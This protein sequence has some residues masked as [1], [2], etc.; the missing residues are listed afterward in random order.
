MAAGGGRWR[1]GDRK[2]LAAILLV[3]ISGCTRRQT[4]EVFG[5]SWSTVYRRFTEWSGARSKV[6][7]VTERTGL[8]LSIGIAA[9]DTRDSLGLEP[10]GARDP[11]DPIPPPTPS[12]QTCQAPRRQG[13]RLREPAETAPRPRH[14]APHR[15]QRHRKPRLLRRITR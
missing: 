1:H 11:A 8:P 5:P 7:S 13:L 6:Q 15:P 12:A 14:R 3:A 10:P 2:V 9:A 4:P